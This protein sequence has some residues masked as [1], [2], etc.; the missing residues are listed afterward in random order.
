SVRL[1]AL[2][3]PRAAAAILWA[4]STFERPPGFPIQYAPPPGLGPVQTE[5]IRTESVSKNGLTATLFHLAERKL[6]ELRQISKDDW[7]VTGTAQPS[8]WADIDP[9]GVAVGSALKV[10]G[11]G[12]EFKAEK[13]ATAGGDLR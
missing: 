8:A 11:P 2:T 4:R 9:V 3:R 7:N 6:V 12:A 5:Y 1:L 10:I 13:A